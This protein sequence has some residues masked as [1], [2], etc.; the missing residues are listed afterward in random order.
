[1]PATPYCHGMGRG[2]TEDAVSVGAV[3]CVSAQPYLRWTVIAVNARDDAQ[4]DV[5][6]RSTA[7]PAVE[8]VVSLAVLQ[9]PLRFRH[10]EA[11]T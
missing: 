7:D 4:P 8:R 5:V 3:Y 9:N 1:V 11:A 2:T 10:I 6:L